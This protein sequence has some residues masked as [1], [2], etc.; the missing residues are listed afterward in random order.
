MKTTHTVEVGP[1]LEIT[2]GMKKKEKNKKRKQFIAGPST[3]K[4]MS[5]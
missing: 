3:V 2:A 4:Q 1:S 5:E